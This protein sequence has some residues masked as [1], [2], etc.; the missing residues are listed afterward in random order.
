M[1]SRVAAWVDFLLAFVRFAIG[2]DDDFLLEL[3]DEVT[4]ESIVG[5]EIMDSLMN[6]ESAEDS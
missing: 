6:S 2:K 3:D 4:L 1:Q 5:K